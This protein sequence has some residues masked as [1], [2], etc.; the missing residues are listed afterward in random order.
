M[1]RQAAALPAAFSLLALA[2]APPALGQPSG[3]PP[4]GEVFAETIDVSVVNVEVFVSDRAGHPV[5]GLRREDFELRVDG[6][7]VPI[8]NFYASAAPPEATA[9]NASVGAPASVPEAQRLTLVI[10]VDEVNLSQEGRARALPA[11]E[12]FLRASLGPTDRVIVAV[13]Q[14]AD[15]KVRL[16]PPGDIP[17]ILAALREVPTR[18]AR[19]VHPPSEA[20][21]SARDL[22]LDGGDGKADLATP[23]GPI[24]G[25][26]ESA[27][28]L[29]LRSLKD[30][31]DSVAGLPGRK[32]VLYLTERLAVE[33]HDPLF[34][35]LVE[36]AS[37]EQVTLYGMGAA[38]PRYAL[39][40]RNG[41]GSDLERTLADLT[42]PTGGLSQ[43]NGLA[44]PAFLDRI[45][46]DLGSYYSLGFAPDSPHDLGSHRLE[47]RVPGRPGVTV[48]FPASYAGRPSEERLAD[49]AVAALDL[50]VADN[51]LG[52]R[53]AVEG[54]RPAAAGR[55][56]VSLLIEMPVSSF[57]LVPSEG[58]RQG[59]VA[60]A[61]VGRDAQGKRLPPQRA[62][63]PVRVPEAKLAAL[64]GKTAAHRLVLDL[65]T[66]STRVAVAF[67]DELG[68]RESVMVGAFDVGGRAAPGSA[69]PAAARRRPAAPAERPPSLPPP[70]RDPWPPP[71]G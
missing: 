49:R 22:G 57:T 7:P 8:T 26:S 48:R 41:L 23:R 1:L 4:P 53:L 63:I 30:F 47:V 40:A 58:V 66:G 55:R 60:L 6:R 19:G 59:R 43:A 25:E 15:L 32:A 21:L 56:Q 13:K 42:T 45:R 70:G 3:S 31:V 14:G 62:V 52:V 24:T 10:L 28:R 51:P 38:E 71:G 39:G 34:R 5:N 11:L 27:G 33:V 17:A 46:G 35:D 54:E 2:L 44:G 50:G 65:P 37:A 18:M 67:S 16:P 69:A 9:P 36:R 68:G 12:T 29:L 20:E 61:I 64:Q